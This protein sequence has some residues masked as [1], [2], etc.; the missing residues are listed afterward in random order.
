MNTFYLA[1]Q[2][3]FTTLKIR[4]QFVSG[5]TKGEGCYEKRGQ[6]WTEERRGL[7]TGRNVRT[8]FM[9]DHRCCNERKLI[10]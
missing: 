8:S 9:D 2:G 5:R 3:W 7:K 4:S 10:L 6:T 1:V